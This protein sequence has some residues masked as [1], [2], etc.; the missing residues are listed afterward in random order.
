VHATVRPCVA[1]YVSHLGAP[2]TLDFG[3]GILI[4]F[5]GLPSVAP[6]EP[7]E[8]GDPHSLFMAAAAAAACSSALFFFSSSSSLACIHSHEPC[9]YFGQRCSHQWDW[10]ACTCCTFC[11]RKCTVLVAGMLVMSQTF[12]SCQGES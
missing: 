9:A 2:N 7:V 10:S 12:L 3:L 6:G 1:G 8:S 4:V 5:K 11:N